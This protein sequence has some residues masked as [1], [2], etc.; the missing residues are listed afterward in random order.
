[1]GESR[2]NSRFSPNTAA[3][4]STPPESLSSA[5]SRAGSQSSSSHRTSRDGSGRNYPAGPS[6]QS[7][8]DPSAPYPRPEDRH[9]SSSSSS[10]YRQSMIPPEQERPAPPIRH[11][12]PP[13]LAPYLSPLDDRQ[14]A[15][16]G[17]GGRSY[18]E[19]RAAHPSLSSLSG[20][21]PSVPPPQRPAP[22][23]IP[24]PP[25]RSQPP[26]S[27]PASRGAYAANAHYGAPPASS[28]YSP[29]N[30]YRSHR[31]LS[32]PSSRGDHHPAPPRSSHRPIL[33][34][35]QGR[36]HSQ[37]SHH[38]SGFSAPPTRRISM[39]PSVGGSDHDDELDGRE[40]ATSEPAAEGPALQRPKRTRVLMTHLQQHRLGA[41]WKKV[42][43][44]G[45]V[46]GFCG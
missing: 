2:S 25:G 3:S 45:D 11:L 12:A 15:F 21:N 34:D 43:L 29:V 46:A 6:R 5:G 33:L 24:P 39:S 37:S 17:S 19:S 35:E 8:H 36:S 13:P 10:S 40:H 26:P 22:S 27:P 9:R 20:R 41:L 28:R 7:I 38:S 31:M 14:F 42:D 32:P 18:H 30:E 44:T 23:H 1:M 16:S 4:V